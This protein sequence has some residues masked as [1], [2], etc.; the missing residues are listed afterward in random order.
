MADAGQ[1]PSRGA[2]EGGKATCRGARVG[3][4]ADPVTFSPM[5]SNVARLMT[6][7]TA[8]L[9]VG[10]GGGSGNKSAT[11]SSAGANSSVVNARNGGFSTGVP[12]GFTYRPSV[13]QYLANGPVTG[14]LVSTL[15]VVRQPAQEG[16]VATIAHRTLRALRRPPKAQDVSRLRS[17]SVDGEPALAVDYVVTAPKAQH[18]ALV[19]VRHGEW[20]YSIRAF[21][22]PTLYQVASEALEELIRNWHWL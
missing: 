11:T 17:L 2:Y 22:S 21:A 20:V 9:F 7:A 5:T 16:S 19:F 14:D 1:R 4:R 8:T 6:I 12:R 15:V 13:A 18:V 10:C 3:P